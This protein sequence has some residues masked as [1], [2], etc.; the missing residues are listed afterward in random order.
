MFQ[1]ISNQSVQMQANQYLSG[2]GSR[3]GWMTLFGPALIAAVAYVDPGNFATNIE[4]GSRYGYQLLWVVLAANIMAMLI[5][6]LAARLG[7][8]TGLNLAEMIR[9]H[10]PK[11]VVW[12]YWIQAELVAIATDLAEFLGAA[13]AFNLLFGL[14]MMQGA[15]LTGVITYLALHLQRLGFRTLEI[16]IGAMVMAIA[17]GFLVELYFSHP[18]PGS[19]L[20][21]MLVPGF[22]D[23]YGVYLAA[24]ILGATIMPHVIYLHSALSQKRVVVKGDQDRRKLMKYYRYDVVFGMTL[25]GIVNM[26]LLALAASAFHG[27][28][29]ENVAT[30]SESYQLLTPLMGGEMA[31]YI[32]G[33]GLLL[34]GLSSSIVGTMSGQVLMQGFVK[35]TIPLGVRRLIT[36]LPALAVIMVG[37][38]EQKAL[39]ASQVVLSFGI[40][41]ALIPLLKF[42]ADPKLMGS[43]VNGRWMS[44]IGGAVCTLIIFLNVYVLFFT[45]SE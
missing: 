20:K 15:I 5:Q 31:S 18:D 27:H 19:L 44:L 23:G 17:C 41:F 30:I 33:F 22:S 36:M 4:A 3:F 16:V 10:A 40:P 32:F 8:A 1:S 12:F 29:H 37:V 14:T 13:L 21:G 25:A 35:F 2:K 11:P 45:F 39:V 26:A 42:T 24:G 9:E 34:A 38:S 43:L 7:L 6:G 28:G